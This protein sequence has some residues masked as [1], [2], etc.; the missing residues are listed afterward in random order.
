MAKIPT[1][2]EPG[3]ADGKLATSG[4][5]F[6]E[7]KGMFQSELN[8]IQDTLNSD[9]S[10]KPLSA[11]QGKIIKTLLDSKVIAAGSIP[12]DTEPIEGN[13]DHVISS[14][15]VYKQSTASKQR[16]TDT[17]N[18]ETQN[19]QDAIDY[20][21]DKS[22]KHQSTISDLISDISDNMAN[23]KWN[24]TPI[25]NVKDLGENFINEKG[26]LTPASNFK[27]CSYLL[28]ANSIYSI[29]AS[30]FNGYVALYADVDLQNLLYV[31]PT[32][33]T[34]VTHKYISVKQDCYL[35]IG[36]SIFIPATICRCVSASTNLFNISHPD[37]YIGYVDWNTGKLADN[38]NFVTQPLVEC[39]AN[40]K[41]T[42]NDI[43][44]IAFYN[45]DKIFISG[46]KVDDQFTVV[47]PDNAAYMMISI[48]NTRNVYKNGMFCICEG[49]SA[50]YMPYLI[51]TSNIGTK[52][53]KTF[54]LDDE[55]VTTEKF[56]YQSIDIHK[57]H[58]SIVD[59]KNIIN[60]KQSKVGLLYNGVLYPSYS[61][62][63][64]LSKLLV[65][66]NTTY[67]V[68][69]NGV[70]TNFIDRLYGYDK[71]NNY[72]EEI[73]ISSAKFTTSSETYYISL[74]YKANVENNNIQVEEG[75]SVTPYTPYI[76]IISKKVLPDFTP[77]PKSISGSQI[78][79]DTIEN[80]N[81]KKGTI[82]IKKL[83]DT[84]IGKNILNPKT[85]IPYGY[86]DINN[87]N[88]GDWRPYGTRYS[89]CTDFIEISDGGLVCNKPAY[90]GELSGYAVYDANK[91]YIRGGR[92]AAVDYQE[93]DKYVRFTLKPNETEVQIEKGSI[94]TEYE[95]YSYKLS[96]KV[97]PKVAI[98]DVTFTEPSK[99]L[100]DPT[101]LKD[102][103]YIDYTNGNIGNWSAGS[104][105]SRTTDFIP[106]N[107][108]GL[109]L[110]KPYKGGTIVGMAVYNSSKEFIRGEKVSGL[111]IYESGDAYVRFTVTYDEDV[112]IEKGLTI[113]SYESYGM[114][115]I[116][117]AL[118]IPDNKTSETVYLSLP[119]V[120]HAIVG[121][122]LQIFYRGI[123][124]APNPYNYNILVSCAK[125]KQFSRYFEY[126]PTINDIGSIPFSITIKNVE[127]KIVGTISSTLMTV[128]APKTP[129]SLNNIACFGDSLTRAGKWCAE[130]DR[131][132]TSTGGT[133]SGKGITNIAF[134]GSKKNG[135]T[136]Y[137]GEGGWTWNSYTGS[138]SPAFRFIVFNVVT[139]STGAVYTN[140]G[141]TYTLIE[142]NS[143]NGNILMSVS[144]ASDTPTSSGTLTKVSG[145]GDN[146]IEFSSFTIDSQNPLWD[147]ENSK[148]SF[149]PYVNKYCNGRLDTV[150]TLLSWNDQKPWEDK[151]TDI[152]NQIKF[153]ARTLH[154]EYPNAKLKLMG[155]QVPDCNG[156]MG[157]AY[158]ATGSGYA[159]WYGH[160][161]TVLHMNQAYEELALSDEFKDYV[162]FINISAEFDSEYL[163]PY[164][165]VPVNT[166]L[167]SVIEK[168]GI[169]GVHPSDEGYKAIGDIV[170][171]NLVATLCQ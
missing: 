117:S 37:M 28:Q 113:T 122:T 5:I 95:P 125:G 74:S 137:F 126:T 29:Q 150:I 160:V 42:G 78:A 157:S 104:R 57:F 145:S 109:I 100:L 90:P 9:E 69:M 11:K 132:L 89:D 23:F 44:I 127:G 108:E 88:Q 6:D 168:R 98:D 162:E 50:E 144:S 62:Y 91:H 128:A 76:P 101:T 72:I 158:G 39:K 1:I 116:S 94:S 171:R 148:M 79:D 30:I 61:D 103:T 38:N 68:S 12:I 135:T 73:L 149:I 59:S 26:I 34:N 83:K 84:Y 118:R 163:M 138:G 167:S 70:A 140:N 4:A 112:Q 166:R 51:P 24:K 120:I 110:N 36:V 77:L 154:Q 32:T 33:H 19:I 60:I 164:N 86:I 165:E 147:V 93:G 130:A 156:G 52:V 49:D 56:A 155:I 53:V 169:N 10:N 7:N 99:N 141:H 65:K 161:Y 25:E 102:D 47:S 21:I 43:F 63:K 131:R 64:S 146:T 20:A 129:A 71:D 115:I 124:C 111:Y 16:Y 40:T 151:F 121:D 31:I 8:D 67:I 143:S 18:I 152:L 92:A 170:Y 85:V 13:I 55:A 22:Q 41:Y 159:D 153:F 134:V 2:L 81:I 45:R 82:E 46:I 142:N 119:K 48:N 35:G 123:I 87:G 58:S 80:N 97:L 133:P 105:L 66:P 54:N 14:D 75:T 114:K 96:K 136:G 106:V 107:T 3:R 139:A 27:C 15:A 17:H